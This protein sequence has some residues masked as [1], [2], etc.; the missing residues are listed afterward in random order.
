MPISTP[1]Q[2]KVPFATSGLKNAIPSE[3]NPVT[4]NAGYDAG[5]PATN[6]TP[7]EAGGIPPFGQDFNGILFDITTAIQYLEAGMQFP[8]SSSF[9][10]AVG[11]YPLGAIVTRTDGTGFWRNTVPNNTTNPETF[12]AGWQPEGAGI[13]TISMSNAN[14]TLTALQAARPII[15]ISGTLTASLN[16]IFP[17]Y[18]RQWLVVN[19]ATGAFSVTC[20]TSAGSGVSIATGLSQSIYGDGTNIGSA[21]ATPIQQSVV[22]AFSNLKIST[23]GTNAQVSVTVDE[24]S[25][26]ASAGSYLT[27][28]AVSLTLFSNGTGAGGI[29]TGSSVASTWYSIWVISNGT[30]TSGLL[31]LS[32]TSPT[33][34]AGYTYKARVGWMRTDASGS[35]YPLSM[36]QSGRVVRYKVATGSNVTSAQSMASG[37]TNLT[38]SATATGNFIP[39]TATVLHASVFLANVNSGFVGVSPNQAY[40]LPTAGTPVSFT[41]SSFP[42]AV[43][44]P[45]TGS[46]V[47][48]Q[49]GRIY[50]ET[51]TVYYVSLTA[52]VA[53]NLI[54][55][56]WEDNL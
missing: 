51:S 31:S 49:E 41:A 28:R 52:S 14:V 56:G 25:L 54:C 13:S 11:G 20:K 9:A 34:P 16:L 29:D 21:S 10:T 22:G 55:L 23:T 17:T 36:I 37:N 30:T 44:T 8:Y 7:K 35:K 19:N 18:Q 42:V 6:M 45:T 3:S 43:G 47:F 33:M 48:M 53:A 40:P 2:I 15:I 26:E 4:G 32:T 1:S 38:Y 27:A 12:G 5:F 39:P 46:P 24:I 50:L